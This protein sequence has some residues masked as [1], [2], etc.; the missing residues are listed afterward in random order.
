MALPQHFPAWTRSPSHP[1][2]LVSIH[3]PRTVPTQLTDVSMDV[4]KYP[5]SFSFP[6][7]LTAFQVRMKQENF[8]SRFAVTDALTAI[9]FLLPKL[10]RQTIP[11]TRLG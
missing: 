5:I 1:M 8:L 3:H 2:L 10:H 6:L 9:C 4:V 11:S 7:L